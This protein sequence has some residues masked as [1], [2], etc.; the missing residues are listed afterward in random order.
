MGEES[1]LDPTC[2][3]QADVDAAA[4]RLAAILAEESAEVVTIY[5]EIGG[6]GHPDHIQVHRV[7]VRATELARTPVVYE[8]TINKDY[9]VELLG[10]WGEPPPD[11]VG[12]A[13]FGVPDNV[14]TTRVDVRPFLNLKRKAMAAHASQV[15]DT[16][17]FL[18]QPPDRFEA[19]WGTEWFI[20]RGVPAGFRSEWLFEE[21]GTR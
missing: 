5:D 13:D 18:D 6:Y 3:W 8:S 2:F 14:I 12:E 1:N 7:G 10:E 21:A 9:Y 15:A 20:R 17:F 16:S 4:G 11:A 19:L